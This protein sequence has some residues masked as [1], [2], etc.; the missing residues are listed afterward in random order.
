MVTGDVGAV[1]RLC[2]ELGYPVDEEVLAT[3]LQWLVDSADNWLAVAEDDD[4]G[5]V[6]WIHVVRGVSVLSGEHAEI[7]ALVVTAARRRA[8][9]GGQLL[10][11]ALCWAAASGVPRLT[12]RSRVER[13]DAHRFYTRNGFRRWKTQAVFERAVPGES[14]GGS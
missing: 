1:T 7:A 3:R 10:R 8:G 9:V 6:G 2:A 13:A 4:V 14:D 11:S 5:V 12:V